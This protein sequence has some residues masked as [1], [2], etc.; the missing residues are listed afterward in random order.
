MKKTL[1]T[2]SILIVSTTSIIAQHDVKINLAGF[3]VQDYGLGYEY[4]INDN[5]S[6]GVFVNYSTFPYII[7]VDEI[8]ASGKSPHTRRSFNFS[9][10]AR[11]Y[12]SPNFGADKRYVGA[13]FRYKTATWE[14]LNYYEDETTNHF[15]NINY[16]SIILGIATGQKWVTNSGVYFETYLG[17]GKAITSNVNFSDIESEQY[18]EDNGG[19][20]NYEY[21]ASWDLRFQVAVGYRI[22]SD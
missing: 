6:A 2:L 22:S 7:A 13:Y 3:I 1:L 11:Y 17:I 9:P 20:E 12:L 21:V 14:D 4:I 19:I 10:E 8:F 5:F 15:Y 16:S 18:I